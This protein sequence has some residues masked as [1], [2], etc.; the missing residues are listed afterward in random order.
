MGLTPP[1]LGWSRGCGNG[2]GYSH[3]KNEYQAGVAV[4]NF[5]EERAREDMQK[6]GIHMFGFQQPG[7]FN[8]CYRQAHTRSAE[9]YALAL[10]GRTADIPRQFLKED[11]GKK[12][13]IDQE[14]P[15]GA[16]A[17][18]PYTTVSSLAFAAPSLDKRTLQKDLWSGVK[19]NDLRMT[20]RAE[21]RDRR[22]PGSL[23]AAKTRKWEQESVPERR[24]LYTTVTATFTADAAARA[25]VAASEAVSSGRSAAPASARADIA[26]RATTDGSH[27]P[28]VGR[29]VTGEFV[30]A[31]DLR[32]RTFR[33]LHFRHPVLHTVQ[34][35]TQAE[36]DAAAAA[37]SGAMQAAETA[38]LGESGIADVAPGHAATTDPNC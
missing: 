20:W 14:T 8:T 38:P 30:D 31:A 37:A 10:E 16:E 2:I 5:L 23:L 6:Q 18:D 27:A 9:E 19:D 4:N 26:A 22:A 11:K 17:P 1:E 29:K 32:E 21:N 24:S 25:V 35:R 33:K 34:W 28:M 15:G 13:L 36:V 3:H 7:N 12:A